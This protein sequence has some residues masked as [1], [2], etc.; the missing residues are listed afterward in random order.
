ML[1]FIK[2]KFK[3]ITEKKPKKILNFE[4]K[5]NSS[6]INLC[7]YNCYLDN[8]KKY[9]HEIDGYV[10]DG[11]GMVWN[12]DKKNHLVYKN[13]FSGEYMKID[14][15]YIGISLKDFRKMIV[16]MDK[17]TALDIISNTINKNKIDSSTDL[18]TLLNELYDDLKW[19]ILLYA[20]SYKISTISKYK[21]Y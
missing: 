21:F 6:L 13:I 1:T 10:C 20:E 18:S 14:N 8:E 7:C 17:K 4:I 15:S 16:E 11:C 5:I 9:N 19:K 3:F 2:N 12:Y